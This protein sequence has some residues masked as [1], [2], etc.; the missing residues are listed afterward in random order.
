MFE[1]LFGK[2]KDN[3]KGE[4]SFESSVPGVAHFNGKPSDVVEY[5]SGDVDDLE[6]KS[7]RGIDNERLRLSRDKTGRYQPFPNR[8]SQE[9]RYKNKRTP[10]I[11]GGVLKDDHDK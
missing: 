4:D 8:G 10:G 9:Y 5:V 3:I 1:G 11:E 2:R 6:L 7:D